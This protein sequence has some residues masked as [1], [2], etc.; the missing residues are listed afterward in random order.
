M[1]VPQILR[2][3]FILIPASPGLSLVVW[4]RQSSPRRGQEGTQGDGVSGVEKY[5]E[6]MA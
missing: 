6:A 1:A 3:L 5:C 4:E 2:R